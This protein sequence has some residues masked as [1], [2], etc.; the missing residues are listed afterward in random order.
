MGA[1]CNGIE[2]VNIVTSGTLGQRINLSH[3]SQSLPD[4]FSYDV[5]IYH[6]GYLKLSKYTATLY[7]TG[8]YIISGVKSINDI[9]TNYEEMKVLLNEFIDTSLVQMAEIKNLVACSSVGHDINLSLLFMDLV[10]STDY[11]ISYE[12]EVFPGMS[13]KTPI[14]TSNIYRNGKYILLGTTNIESL[15]DLNLQ[16][17]DLIEC[18]FAYRRG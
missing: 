9:Q 12:P 8:K 5:E 15:R 17:H 10:A 13:V 3:L 7:S 14:G 18:H 6:G 11:E 2:I 16:I 4:L 1:G